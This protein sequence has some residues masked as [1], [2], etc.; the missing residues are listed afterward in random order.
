MF[1]PKKNKMMKK[2]KNC[3]VCIRI[4]VAFTSHLRHYGCRIN[5]W[6]SIYAL[7]HHNM[8]CLTLNVHMQLCSLSY[9]THHYHF[10]PSVR[11]SSIHNNVCPFKSKLREIIFL[12]QMLPQAKSSKQSLHQTAPPNL[13]PNLL[14]S[15]A[16]P[17]I[18]TKS[19]SPTINKYLNQYASSQTVKKLPKLI[20]NIPHTHNEAHCPQPLLYLTLTQLQIQT[21]LVFPH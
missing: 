20:N 11:D 19:L 18:S 4:L 1:N 8:V 7:L 16:N 13:L 17:I 15:C 10:V 2:K 14:P 5:K 3:L 12:A 21:I 9:I 6:G